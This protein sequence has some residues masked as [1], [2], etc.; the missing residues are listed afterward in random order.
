MKRFLSFLIIIMIFFTGCSAVGNA[1]MDDAVKPSGEA[2]AN[3]VDAIIKNINFNDLKGYNLN[4]I[5]GENKQAFGFSTTIKSSNIAVNI[6]DGG[7]KLITGATVDEI[8]AQYLDLV[9]SGEFSGNLS[10]ILL[11]SPTTLFDFS[12]ENLRSFYKNLSPEVYYLDIYENRVK[13]ALPILSNQFLVIEDVLNLKVT[14]FNNSNDI[15]IEIEVSVQFS[16]SAISQKINV[17]VVFEF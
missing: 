2:H 14:L 11:S 15:K 1:T 5:V 17:E 13:D 10:G 16:D 8:N 9:N 7:E 4:F 12:Q 3:E 6:T